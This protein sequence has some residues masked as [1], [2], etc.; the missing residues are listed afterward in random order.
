MT[1]PYARAE[2]NYTRYG[3]VLD[4]LTTVDD[5]FVV[6]GSGEGVKLDFDPHN[7]PALP[8]GWVR[9]YFFYANG[10]EK[11][12][13]FYAAYAFSV[14]PLP[15]HGMIALSV[16]ARKR[17]SGGCAASRLRTGIQHARAFGPIAA[18]PSLSLCSAERKLGQFPKTLKRSQVKY[19]E[20]CHSR[21]RCVFCRPCFAGFSPIRP[22]P[23]L[24]I[25]SSSGRRRRVAF[26]RGRFQKSEM[27]EARSNL[28]FR[29]TRR[30]RGRAA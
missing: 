27:F 14:E 23:T 3:D 26:R 12:L 13:D 1:G 17:I 5:R 18:E 16:S 10:F 19:S 11:D 24:W 4:L 8:A 29:C 28:L 7:L 9:D 15:R 25:A 6:F 2:G 22:A 21:F 30:S 20:R